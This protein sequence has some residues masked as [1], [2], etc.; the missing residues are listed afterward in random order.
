MRGEPASAWD[1]GNSTIWEEYT[2]IA[3]VVANSLILLIT[4]TVGIAANIFVLLAVYHQKSLQTCNNALVVNLAVV[5][6]LRCVTDCPILLTI[7]LTVHQRG[8][9]DGLI[10]DTQVASFSFS[11]CIQLLTLACI[12]AERYQAIAQPFKT[13]QR[14]RRIMVL[15]PVIWTLAIVVAGVCLIFVKDSPVHMRCKGLQQEGTSSYDTFGLYMLFPLW[16]ACFGVIIGFYARIFILVR[17]HNRKIF[18]KGTTL[19][20]GDKTEEKQ[21]NGET[22]VVE[23]GHEKS[24]QKQTLSKSVAQVEPVTQAKPN[25]SNKDS[26]SALLT[27]TKAV[28]CVSNCSGNKTELKN[29]LEITDFEREQP[30]PPALQVVV[31][32]E[33]KPLKTEEPSS[34]AKKVEAKPSNGDA[35]ASVKSSATKPQKVSSNFD[36]E[37]QSKETTAAI[38][39]VEIL[40]VSVACITS[41]SDPIIYAAVN[42]QFRTEFY[43]LKNRAESIFKKK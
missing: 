19:S 42:P 10:C 32:T 18:D 13:S 43:K 36:A 9:V 4:S 2:D 21:K 7:V 38:Q 5:D 26:T 11:C 15:I 12:S 16:V 35:V 41:L 29:T 14:R 6:F 20:K 1:S 33:E 34:C 23:N 37:K 8:R 27:S 24:E 40:S 31:Q 30:C 3:F 28:Q 22:T 25:S 39:D 17:S